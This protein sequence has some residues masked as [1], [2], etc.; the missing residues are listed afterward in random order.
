MLSYWGQ[1]VYKFSKN[2]LDKLLN[3]IL[4]STVGDRIEMD[5][6]ASS[7][8]IRQ[9]FYNPRESKSIHFFTQTPKQGMFEVRIQNKSGDLSSKSAIEK[10][11][12][13]LLDKFHALSMYYTK[14]RK[15]TDD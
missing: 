15:I 12:S 9:F 6:K 11:R 10:K 14:L 8:I 5:Q 3:T 1:D 13:R 4:I 2:N 7:Y